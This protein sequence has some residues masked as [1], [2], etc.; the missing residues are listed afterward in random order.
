MSKK[1]QKSIRKRTY[2]GIRTSPPCLPSTISFCLFGPAAVGLGAQSPTATRQLVTQRSIPQRD[3]PDPSKVAERTRSPSAPAI[4]RVRP[5]ALRAAVQRA[6]T[7]KAPVRS[8]SAPGR[9]V[10]P[11]KGLTIPAPGAGLVAGLA[12][13]TA[14]A[15]VR[16]VAPS[17]P[18]VR[19]PR[20]RSKP[21]PVGP[22]I[23]RQPPT[24]RPRATPK[25]A[26]LRA[27]AA[28]G[29]LVVAQA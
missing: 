11:L 10:R 12:A 13:T 28:L 22:F 8:V 19:S 27:A 3:T 29:G 6:I 26:P 9:L 23:E 7:T 25:G 14:D 2:T 17:R 24:A 20:R 16:Q 1:C 21:L 4:Q 5:A 18:P 15:V